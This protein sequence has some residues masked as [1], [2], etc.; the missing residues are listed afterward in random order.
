MTA[1]DKGPNSVL[2]RRSPVFIALQHVGK[3]WQQSSN[4]VT[5][6]K[7]LN[8]ENGGKGDKET[9]GENCRRKKKK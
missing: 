1:N 8:G 4:S 6:R 9:W 5:Q 2:S 7:I 3:H